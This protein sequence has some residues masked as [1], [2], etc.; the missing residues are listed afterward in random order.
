M[1][2]SELTKTPGLVAQLSRETGVSMA[3]IS[4]RIRQGWHIGI[5][6]GEMVM[7]N[8]KQLTKIGEVHKAAFKEWS[9]ENDS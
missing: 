5:L 3:N 1:Q 7:Y 9:K 4:Y 8:P 6:N 2:L